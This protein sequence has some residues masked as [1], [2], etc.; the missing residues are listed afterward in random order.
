MVFGRTALMR[1]VLTILVL[2]AAAF[3]GSAEEQRDKDVEDVRRRAGQGEAE[4][5]YNLGLMYQT[6]RGV[7]QDDAE[8]VRLY[9]RAADQGHTGAQN[10]LGWMYAN[11]LGVK[12][13]NA[14]AV[15]WYRSAADQ[16]HDDAQVNLGRCIELGKA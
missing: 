12:R 8:A 13:D 2:L 11:G 15:K 16:G 4:A 3:T 14:E 6:G 1:T 10:N 9:R 5:Q 7:K